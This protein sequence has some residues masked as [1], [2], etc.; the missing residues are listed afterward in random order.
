MLRGSMFFL[1]KKCRFLYNGKVAAGVS[2]TRYRGIIQW[3]YHGL[4]TVHGG[5]NPSSP[6]WA[7]IR[8]DSC[9]SVRKAYGLT[10]PHRSAKLT[11]RQFVC[12]ILSL[13]KTRATGSEN[14]CRSL[15]LR[16]FIFRKGLSMYLLKSESSFDSAHFLPGYEGRCRNLHGHRWRIVAEIHADALQEEGPLRG[17]VTDFSTFKQVLSDLTDHYDHALLV[18]EGSLH[19]QTVAAMQEENFHMIFL[20]FRPTAENFAA[21]FYEK[22]E[23]AGYNV[24]EVSVYETPNNCAIYRK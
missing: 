20:P 23:E 4:Q 16:F 12:T 1:D 21:F 2:G 10:F 11:H 19:P 7:G 13:N 17:M 14:L 22:L 24:Y 8:T 5:S 15:V 18:E 9:F 3:Q 6:A